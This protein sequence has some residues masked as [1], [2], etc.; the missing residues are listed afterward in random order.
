ML[1]DERKEGLDLVSSGEGFKLSV[2]G[3]H[4]LEGLGHMPAGAS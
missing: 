1:R 3:G 4:G 2:M